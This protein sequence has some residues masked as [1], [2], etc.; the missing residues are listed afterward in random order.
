MAPGSTLYAYLHGHIYA[1]GPVKTDRLR[2]TPGKVR[3]WTPRTP[4]RH[5]A[6]ANLNPCVREVTGDC[7]PR[8]KLLNL[9][10]RPSPTLITYLHYPLRLDN[11]NKSTTLAGADLEPCP[12][13]RKLARPT[14]ARQTT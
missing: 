11:E 13:T 8:V 6:D 1:P 2:Q 9:T 10:S 3:D 5:S 12:P 7:S 14:W 4:S